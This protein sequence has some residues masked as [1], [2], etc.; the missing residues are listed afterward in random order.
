[1]VKLGFVQFA[2]YDLLESD[3]IFMN[4]RSDLYTRQR[5]KAEKLFILL[6]TKQQAPRDTSQPHPTMSHQNTTVRD[7]ISHQQLVM[8][9]PKETLEKTFAI[10]LK[11]NI[12][13]LPV[14]DDQ[15][16]VIGMVSDRDI[17]LAADSPILNKGMKSL[18]S[19]QLTEIVT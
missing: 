2:E 19:L 14:I 4:F 15:G 17:R 11:H 9:G 7:L 12:R 16:A 6:F 3:E 8:V 18:T 10:M 5:Q 1:M 13:H